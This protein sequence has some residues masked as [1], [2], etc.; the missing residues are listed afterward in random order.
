[1][2][3]NETRPKCARLVQYL[4]ELVR[5]RSKTISDV[6]SYEQVMWLGRL[7]EEDECFSRHREDAHEDDPDL[8]IEIRKPREPRLP[9]PPEQCKPWI[10]EWNRDDHDVEPQLRETILRPIWANDEA[11]SEEDAE[12][13][14]QFSSNAPFSEEV[15]APS[16]EELRLE[17]HLAVWSAWDAYIESQWRP[18]AAER[19]RWQSIQDRYAE[20]FEIHSHLQTRGEQVELLLGVGLLCWS[21][22]STRIR[23]HFVTGRV[24]LDF[25][26]KRARF[27]VRPHTAGAQLNVEFDMLPPERR[28]PGMEAAAAQGLAAAGEDIW[29]RG[30]IDPVLNSLAHLLS[31]HGVYLREND[32]PEIAAGEHPVVLYAPALILRR[33]SQR[34][35]QEFLHKI[36]EQLSAG[37]S[38]P[39]GWRDLCEEIEGHDE[40]RTMANGSR[41]S[42]ASDTA[43]LPL[44][45]NEEQRRILEALNHPI[46][47]LV[48]G[49]PGTGKSHTIANLVCH[50]LATGNRVLIT[51]QT[52]RALE[53]LR[54]KLPAEIRPLAVSLLGAGADEQ[55]SLE[56]SVHGIAGRFGQRQVYQYREDAERHAK[57]RQRAEEQIADL[58]N[59]RR[60]L[61]EQDTREHHIAGYVG[62]A[63]RLA[64]QL[65]DEAEQFDW[66]TDAVRHDSALGVTPDAVD[67]ALDTL[68]RIPSGEHECLLRARPAPGSDVPDGQAFKS[69]VESEKSARKALDSSSEPHSSCAHL[70]SPECLPAIRAA[71]KKM[72]VVQVAIANAQR[73]PQSWID[74]A[75][76][77]VLT[78]RDR[79]WFELQLATEEYLGPLRAE[80]RDADRRHVERPPEIDWNQL[81]HDAETLRNH[82]GTGRKPRLWLIKP[83]H[84]KRLKYLAT[85]VRIDGDSC[86]NVES[87]T[88]V[89]EHAKFHLALDHI[90]RL[91][92]GLASPGSES[93]AL[94]VQEIE[95]LQEALEDVLSAY[96][97]VEVA[98][99]AIAALSGVAEPSWD[100]DGSR[101]ELIT[102]LETIAAQIE[103]DEAHRALRDIC[104]RLDL[105]SKRPDSDTECIHGVLE[106]VK[107]MDATAYDAALD[108]LRLRD[109]RAEELRSAQTTLASVGE[110]LP[111]LAGGIAEN[112]K[113]PEW[114]D[115]IAVLQ[116]AFDHARA[117]QWLAEFIETADLD[118]IEEEWRRQEKA[119]SDA[120][121]NAAA[122]LAWAHAFERM[123][124]AHRRAL[125]AWQQ[126]IKALG[127][128]TGKY[129][130]R[131]RREAQAQLQRCRPAIPAWIMPLH[132]VFDS[133]DPEP[134]M[135]DV[136]IIDEASQCGPDALPLFY[137]GKKV[138][139]VGDDKQ[140]S[141]SHVGTNREHVHQRM[142][143]FLD[144]FEHRGS[145]DLERSL[146]DHG[147]LRIGNRIVLREHFRC[148]PEIIRFSNDL[149]YRNT[150]L[151][152]L[153]QYPP[154]RLRPLV[155]KH[156]AEGYREGD[157]SRTL[158]K[159][160]ADQLVDA[161][162]SC[163]NDSRYSA[164]GKKSTI[165][166]ISLQGW[167]QAEYIEH[168]LLQRI[169]AEEMAQRRLLCGDAYSF[170]G[171]E[172]DLMFLSM[173]AAPNMRIGA[174]TRFA[175]QQRFNVAASRAR[176][177]LWLFHSVMP[178]DLSEQCMR[179]MLL[180]HFLDP[181]RT[182][183]HI[184]G[185]KTEDLERIALRADRMRDQPPERFE[186]WF[187]VDVAL[188]LAREG[189]RVVPQFDIGGYRIDMVVEGAMS[190]LAVECDGDRWHG[191]DRYEADLERQRKLERAGWMFARVRG[192]AFYANPD[193]AMAHVW[194]RLASLGIHAPGVRKA[195]SEMATR[196]GI[197]EHVATTNE[198]PEYS[199][200][201]GVTPSDNADG[202]SAS[203]VDA[204]E[205]S[206]ESQHDVHMSPSGSFKVE[207]YREW[208]VIPLVDPRTVSL[209]K[210]ARNLIAIVEVEGPVLASRAY[211]LYA[212]AAGLQRV[213]SA[214]RGVFSRAVSKAVRNGLLELE[215]TDPKAPM[216]SAVLRLAGAPSVRPRTTGPRTFWEIP[217]SE[218]AWVMRQFLD[219]RS[220]IQDEEL[221]RLV[222]DH[223]GFQRLRGPTRER[224][225]E[226]HMSILK[227]D[228]GAA[229]D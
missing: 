8:W 177:Q 40:P 52:P 209:E 54:N 20:L 135:F 200:D 38:T 221:Y 47:A 183:R 106:S 45:A 175:D 98:V 46:G 86:N 158:N 89:I 156:V 150:P 207:P 105:F 78:K 136:V 205:E 173:V 68:R 60:V 100:T 5:L 88:K 228:T 90:W 225:V 191:V 132:R 143:E 187:E 113:L 165:G 72:R 101:K 109:Q 131:H 77:E 19:K 11:D 138:L 211:R 94:Q 140:I 97:C 127:K 58:L 123:E 116:S 194:D 198:P 107:A 102:R 152:P 149:C 108:Q 192:S 96:R 67:A 210:V 184:G 61:R 36:R 13:Q 43:Y 80:A 10:N 145:F 104:D 64:R 224:L 87:L 182:A 28:A 179:R 29:D 63:E 188:C 180:E 168:L 30:A 55:Q 57:A 122:N 126:A 206:A 3:A 142:R 151:I 193:A 157:S 84:L 9:A 75:L 39:P 176:D 223:Y 171:D 144:D 197:R 17:D 112:S 154:Q 195:E 139:I 16:S 35:V 14:S 12:S 73:R 22:G 160:E 227:A 169:G 53:V 130:F 83:G 69:L 163:C 133:I 56:D 118:Q 24:D 128:G 4:E 103:L 141:P 21:A 208:S 71:I 76:Q 7:P 23:R 178:E 70:R 93:L 114:G 49:P 129:A 95:E 65:N 155:A 148:M 212:N 2:S 229:G 44:P 204:N 162:V 219:E 120:I 15:Q 161:I 167:T 203:A 164:N 174:L 190:R 33:R 189:L 32:T 1:M 79:P 81:H 147:E 134:G 27:H 146:F 137:I 41:P 201:M 216:L 31:D 226:I 159:P 117:K 26:E 59:R 153:R 42:R 185:I 202:V 62:T 119:R 74:R 218:I 91:W 34:C 217:L 37:A 111:N 220:P 6:D 92:S 186:S 115:R 25:D 110:L 125:M 18:W 214:L 48:Q 82:F 124:D 166:V 99:E 196:H 215:R 51:A 199:G 222:I 66:F 121:T 85:A 213:G 170:Q 181:A 172:R 50:L